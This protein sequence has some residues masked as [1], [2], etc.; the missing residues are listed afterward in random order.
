MARWTEAEVNQWLTDL[1][2]AREALGETFATMKVGMEP[3]S[4]FTFEGVFAI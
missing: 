4:I 2:W 1:G 3:L